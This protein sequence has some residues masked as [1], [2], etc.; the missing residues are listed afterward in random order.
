[1]PPDL[2]GQSASHLPWHHVNSVIDQW[3]HLPSF[4]VGESLFIGLALLALVH[5][6]KS[7]RDHVL[8]WLAALIAGTANDFIFM[9]LPLVD[10]FWQA[11]ATLMLTPRMPVY[12]PCVYVC[13]MYLPTVAVRR[14]GMGP[15]STAA[16][17]G[18]A[19][20]AFYAPYDIVGAKFLWW[21]WHDTD[22]PIAARLLGVPTSSSLWVVTF[23]GAFAWL[24]NRATR[25]DPQVSTATFVKGLAMVAGLTTLLMMVQMMVLQQ[26]DG[27]TPRYGALIAAL[28]IYSV[29]FVRGGV[30]GQGPNKA[31]RRAG[32]G[33]DRW[34]HR[35]ILVYFATLATIMAVFN[36]ASH[37][38]TGVHQP[39]GKCYVEATDITGQTRHEFLCVTD[40]AED[41]TFDCVAAPPPA[42]TA[43]Y[44]I[45]G[46]PHSDFMAWMLGLLGWWLFGSLLYTWLLTDI[47]HRQRE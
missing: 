26:V 13:F 33:P 31:T 19:G 35:A 40:Y 36:P 38:S 30:L 16:L 34:L 5:A 32:S 4:V 17:S 45:C 2:P 12:I 11:Q 25:D 9:A 18:L 37:K 7:G 44:T 27:G 22:Q 14:L 41:Y 39:P 1:M 46:K 21:T 28:V 43:W 47:G 15:W 8:I 6:R 23:V 10:N 3:A 20:I 29:V 42:A 24:I